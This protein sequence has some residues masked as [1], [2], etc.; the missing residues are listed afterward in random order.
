MADKFRK[1]WSFQRKLKKNSRVEAYEDPISK[2]EVKFTKFKMA[3]RITEKIGCF[4]E[5]L[6][7]IPRTGFRGCDSKNEVKS[8]NFKMAGWI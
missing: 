1:N 4:R 5:N 2:N 8:S 7:K 3:D 6:K